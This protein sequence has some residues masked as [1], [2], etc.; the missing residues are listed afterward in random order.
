MLPITVCEDTKSIEQVLSLTDEEYAKYVDVLAKCKEAYLALDTLD[1]ELLELV[2][3]QPDVVERICRINLIAFE[4][5]SD[6]HLRVYF[7]AYNFNTWLN[8]ALCKRNGLA[9]K[10]IFADGINY[11]RKNKQYAAGKSISQNI[12]RLWTQAM[13]PCDEALYFLM[14]VKEFYEELGKH[15]DCVEVLC[16]AAL[17]F[18]DTA[19]YQSAYRAIHDAQQIVIKKKILNYQASVLETQG[20]VALS[21]GDLD[22]AD[23]EFEKCWKICAQIGETPS[24]Q[25]RA[26]VAL[27]KMRKKNYAIARD[28]Y[29]Q[30]L[31]DD[32]TE[33]D[34]NMS[35]HIRINLLVCCRELSDLKSINT[36][37]QQIESELKKCDLESRIEGK[38]VLSKTYVATKDLPRAG[39]HLKEACLL[40]QERIDN[41]QRLHYRRGVREH[42]VGR[43]KSL[44]TE[45]EPSGSNENVL[46]ALLLCSSNAILD[47]LA[48]LQWCDRVCKS[49]I[50]PQ[51]TKSELNNKL[52]ELI[53]FGTP[54]LYGPREKYDDPFEFASTKA[55]E[56][57]G[58]AVAK[59]ADYSRP[60]REFN[61]VTASICNDFGLNSPFGQASIVKC[62][63]SVKTRLDSGSAFLFTFICEK[64]CEF[65]FVYNGQY[66]HE[67]IDIDSV[68]KFGEALQKYQQD[69]RGHKKE[70]CTQLNNLEEA[71]TPL[72]GKIIAILECN[73]SS[74]LIIVPDML[75]EGMPILPAIIANDKIRR[76]IKEGKFEF[77]T[78]PSIW[79]E[80][81]DGLIEG[82]SIFLSNSEERLE[83]TE[84]EYALVRNAFPP[85]S[86]SSQD[87][88]SAKLDFS[89]PP[90]SLAQH[91][92]LATHSVPANIFSDPNFISTSPDS[93]NNSV[94]LESVQRESHKLQCKLVILDGC[95]TGTTSNRNYYKKFITNEKVGLSSAFLLNRRTVVIAT[96]WNEPEIV[97]FTF[98]SLF[99]Q[100]LKNH[101]HGAKAYIMAIAD[102]FEL[103]VEATIKVFQRILNENIRENRCKLIASAQSQHPFRSAYCLGM[104]QCHS[105]LFK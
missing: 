79:E 94:W 87:L 31:T 16:A 5:F 57:M 28:I 75:T 46:P 78:C 68:I 84:S 43:I 77:L 20:M 53:R 91:L 83:L 48:A 98:S 102:L 60:W 42:Y 17:H 61:D 92:H 99:Y 13:M 30:L 62:V 19:A 90:V 70:F 38:L 21:E 4:K 52:E 23:T 9:A 72:M 105:L 36:L 40:I 59:A 27:V 26:N 65:I 44:L 55:V 15:G 97:S 29:E 93:K 8:A 39:R 24:F 74:A 32:L 12:F 14:Q 3:A 56:Q 86:S 25:L 1:D 51:E 67:T 58:E 80:Q 85:D 37:S 69:G 54:F 41:Y 6:E 76:R 47:W 11:C 89:K 96:Q 49:E 50:I 104:F 18:A 34:E 103:D 71:I 101:K 100:H 95:N 45:I 73:N 22:C 64:G 10:A 2:E 35:Q 66:L 7:L 81:M 82:Q 33:K 63:E 88:N